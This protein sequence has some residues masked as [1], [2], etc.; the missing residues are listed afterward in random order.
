MK[1]ST[2]P[3]PTGEP[4]THTPTTR[5]SPQIVSAKTSSGAE[6]TRGPVHPDLSSTSS[7]PVYVVSVHAHEKHS[8]SPRITDDS[9]SHPSNPEQSCVPRNVSGTEQSSGSNCTDAAS[10]N[11]FELLPRVLMP[12]EPSV[13]NK[14]KQNTDE[15][16]TTAQVI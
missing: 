11:D 10:D 15:G 3:P 8:L 6:Q 14:K 16:G 1:T 9:A 2:V 12:S 4:N 7:A 5:P 13:G